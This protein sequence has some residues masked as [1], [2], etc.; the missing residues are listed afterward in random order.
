[1]P[2]LS[3]EKARR[4]PRRFFGG[5]DRGAVATVVAILLAGGV[6]LGFLSLVVDVGRIY[7]EREELQTGADAAALAVAKACATAATACRTDDGLLD[8]AQSYADVNS[9]DGVSKV[10]GVP[11]ELE[12]FWD[13]LSMSMMSRTPSL[14]SEDTFGSVKLSGC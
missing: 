8:L 9:S 14:M 13:A 3:D 6:L 2:R 5:D 1:M 7:V 10:S 4:T 12:L 11:L